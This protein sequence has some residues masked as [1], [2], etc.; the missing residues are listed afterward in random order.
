LDAPSDFAS[1]ITGSI[2]AR[3]PSRWR[4]MAQQFVQVGIVGLGGFVIDVG[5]FNLLRW[6]LPEWGPIIPKLIST[7]LAILANWLGNRYWTFR[8]E[9]RQEVVREGAEFVIVSAIGA[10]IPLG[11]LAISH[12]VLGYRNQLA[13]N[14]SANVI[15]LVLGT[16]FRFTFYKLWV[17][18]GRRGTRVE[19][20]EPELTGAAAPRS[21]GA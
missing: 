10:L 9:R 16:A 20:A 14:I 6:L 12:Y 5:V 8:G 17:F 7:T 11:C 1:A 18:N 4:E 3:V 19:S 2:V 15:G 13:D 21:S